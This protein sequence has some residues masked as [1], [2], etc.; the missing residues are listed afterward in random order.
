V[1]VLHLIGR[2]LCALG[3]VAILLLGVDLV[4]G[5]AGFEFPGGVLRFLI[6]M[7][8]AVIGALIGFLMV[9]RFSDV[10]QTRRLFLIGATAPPVLI[11]LL[12][13]AA[14]LVSGTT[15]HSLLV[16]FLVVCW[17]AYAAAIVLGAQQLR[18]QGQATFTALCLLGVGAGLLAQS[19]GAVAQLILGP[20]GAWPGLLSFYGIVAAAGLMAVVLV[21]AAVARPS[22]GRV[23]AG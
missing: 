23:S 16:G 7:P 12:L 17:A 1:R 22:I 14:Q 6:L 13:G 9:R 8:T 10:S 4:T 5:H 21:I 20:D 15:A 18:R 19:L 11:L 3:A 2:V